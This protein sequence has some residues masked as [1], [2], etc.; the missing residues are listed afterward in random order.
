MPEPMPKLKTTSLRGRS[1]SLLDEG[2]GPAVLFVH[3]FPLSHCMWQG[4]VDRF[5]TNHRVVIPDLPGFGQSES[6]LDGENPVLSMEFLADWLAEL[7]DAIQCDTPVH[8]CGLSMGGYIGWQF[9]RRHPSRVQSL[10]ACNT[11]AAGDTELIRRGREIAARQ[12]MVAGAKPVADAMVKKLF[13]QA[14][15]GLRETDFFNQIHRVI[16]AAEPASI[17]AG[18]RG[19]AERKDAV[20]WLEGVE[21][22]MLFVA[23]KHDSITPA[24][25]MQQNARRVEHAEYALIADAGHMSPME[26]TAA[27]NA[28]LED[29]LMRCR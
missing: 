8:F 16:A 2:Q 15:K 29:F 7:L 22:P 20:E 25:E 11:R 27:F 9:W 19:M 13:Y 18:Q 4:Q 3:G 26:N 12:V 17:A 21:V 10:I 14:R 24:D 23:G 6:L 28:V 5:K 1:V